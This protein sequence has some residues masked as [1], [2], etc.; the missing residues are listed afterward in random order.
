[1]PATELRKTIFHCLDSTYSLTHYIMVVTRSLIVA[2]LLVTIE[3]SSI[4]AHCD[5]H[6]TGKK[7]RASK[8][9]VPNGNHVSVSSI[10]QL[11]H[12]L[13]ATD[14]QMRNLGISSGEKSQR[15]DY[16][17]QIVTVQKAYLQYVKR[18][19]DHDY[20][21]VL[22]SQKSGGRYFNAEC[23]GLPSTGANNYSALKK[24]RDDFEQIIGGEYC[25]G[26]W[27][28]LHGIPVSV[29]GAFF[30]DVDHGIDVSGPSCC[31]SH[32]CWEIHPITDISVVN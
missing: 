12:S 4:Q 17:R 13:P 6:F 31:K 1:M 16:E 25:S 23:S 18:E 7:R 20:H 26:D 30:Y 32:T 2:S 24:V 21:F 14:A 28:E 3:V 15:S 5:P 22:S 9:S 29:T 19:S 8:I 27:K 10:T 11:A